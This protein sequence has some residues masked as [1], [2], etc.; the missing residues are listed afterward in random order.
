MDLWEVV[1]PSRT[2]SN[3]SA[4]GSADQLMLG[5]VRDTI[6]GLAHH[7]RGPMANTA[8][9]FEIVE[10]IR[11]K[12][13]GTPLEPMLVNL[14][15]EA[16]RTSD[17]LGYVEKLIDIAAI[18]EAAIALNTPLADSRRIRIAPAKAKAYGL[19]GDEQLLVDALDAVIAA[20]LNAAVPAETIVLSV[21]FSRLGIDI[22]VSVPNDPR[23][24]LDME[25]P[26]RLWLARMIAI[27]H[28]GVLAL[29]H[30]ANTLCFTLSL[31]TSLR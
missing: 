26:S 11:R 6:A 24:Q 18:L 22:T 29:R 9:L 2:Q 27:R 3:L 5:A 4:A 17:A 20:A 10:A 14:V 13:A 8:I 16:R 21:S 15:S 23:K 19:L 31:P 25:A 7:M 12:P 28:G 30:E 1:M